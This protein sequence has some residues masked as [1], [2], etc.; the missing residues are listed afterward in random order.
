MPGYLVPGDLEQI[1][2][3]LG[4]TLTE[5][6][7]KF[8]ASPGAVVARVENGQIVVGRIPTIVPTQQSNG[9]CVFLQTDGL[10]SIHSVSPFGCAVTDSHMSQQE[11]EN[12]SSHGLQAIL[13]SEPYQDIW[14]MLYEAGQTTVGPIIQALAKW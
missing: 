5:I 9:H 1:A 2:T 7:D 14:N 10:C 4:K 11:G 13:R 12:R 3:H 8:A 6:L